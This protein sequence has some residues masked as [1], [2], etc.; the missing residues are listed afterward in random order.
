MQPVLLFEIISSTQQRGGGE[1]DDATLSM[2]GANRQALPMH[3]ESK[4]F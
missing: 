3:W 1:D 4:L 2:C